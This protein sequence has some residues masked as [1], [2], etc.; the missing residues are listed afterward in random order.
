MRACCDVQVWMRRRAFRR[1]GC[2]IAI[3]QW[4]AT[5]GEK[6]SSLEIDIMGSFHILFKEESNR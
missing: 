5:P 4:F 2:A 3:H 1:T 6:M